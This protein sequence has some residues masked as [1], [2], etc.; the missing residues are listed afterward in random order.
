MDLL[1]QKY[2]WNTK[3]R[4]IARKNVEISGEKILHYFDIRKWSQK[5]KEK[6]DVN[7]SR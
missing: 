3:K 1:V 7:R 5:E 4:G 6:G 2:V